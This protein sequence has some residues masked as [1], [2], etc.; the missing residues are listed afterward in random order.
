[1]WTGEGQSS[2]WSLKGKD[3]IE[4]V[5]ISLI[6]LLSLHSSNLLQKKHC[7]ISTVPMQNTTDSTSEESCSVKHAHLH[8]LIVTAKTENFKITDEWC[9]A[10]HRSI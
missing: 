2:C 4:L 7:G 9:T 5:R 8:L 10:D 1:M 6:N 3:C